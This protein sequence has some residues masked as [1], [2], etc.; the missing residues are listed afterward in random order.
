MKKIK[1]VFYLP[2]TSGNIWA[3]YEN[4]LKNECEKMGMD[5]TFVDFP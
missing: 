2:G 4:Y 5:I 1:K 3:T